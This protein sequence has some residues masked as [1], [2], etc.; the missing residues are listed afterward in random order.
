MVVR[1]SRDALVIGRLEATVHP[2]WAEVAWVLG[3]DHWGQGYGTEAAGWLIDH[4][5][6]DHGVTELWATVDPGNTASVR[7][8]Q[9]WGFLEQGPQYRRTPE[10]YE[11]GDL[12]YARGLRDDHAL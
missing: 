7:L 5:A 3:P 1:R 12:V 4:L 10:S 11:V 2:G 8:L 9:R 6:T